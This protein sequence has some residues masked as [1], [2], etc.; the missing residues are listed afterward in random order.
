MRI[1]YVAPY[2]GP[3]LLRRRPIVR[4]R[5]MSA[6]TKMELIATLL[7]SRGHEVEIVSQG[8]VIENSLTFYPSFAEPERFHPAIP[9][10]YAS[11]L[12]VRRLNGAWSDR[13]T[14]QLF[15]ARHRASPYDLVM[16]YNLKGPQIACANYA[17]ARRIPVILEYEDDR[18]VNVVGEGPTDLLEKYSYRAC[19]KVIAEAAG[20]I[21]VSPLLLS[22]LPADVPKLLLRGI[23]GD[24]LVRAGQRSTASKR[25][26]ILFSGTH[27]QS[28]GVAELIEAWK[29]TPVAGWELHI[30]GFGGLTDSLRTM[31]AGIGNL[32]FD[33][34]VTRQTL[35][36][37]MS[38][39][40]ICINPHAVSRTPG[41]VFAFKLVE[42]LAAGA[43]VITT[44]MGALEQELEK[45]MTYMPDNLPAT[46]AGALQDVVANR[47]YEATAMDAAH[48]KYG[49]PAVSS[50]LDALVQAVRDRP[51]TTASGPARLST[52]LTR[53][54]TT[55][56]HD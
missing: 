14:L 27:I 30:T 23:V 37:L 12:P 15:K 49:P 43:H 36:E 1:A 10:H 21:A 40:S 52:T 53:R 47:R 8:E 34:L 44:P 51:V 45:G 35:V 24:D 38:S 25:N 5:S 48:Q 11:V 3:T 17:L 33:G 41:N 16:L 56:S 2:H 20:G 50:S 55:A 18:F 7:Q 32:H 46:I 31:A 42:Y 22:K 54:A 9:V 28:N 29:R 19:A 4:N 26:V 13:Q 6:S 39:A